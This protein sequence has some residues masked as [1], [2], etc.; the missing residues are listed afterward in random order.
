MAKATSVVDDVIGVIAAQ[1]PRVQAWYH[2][3][4]P[5]HVATLDELLQAWKSGR[6]GTHKITAS[7][8]ISRIL[9]ARGIA[10]VGPQGVLAWLRK[11][12]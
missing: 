2:R 9:A 1:P 6:L 8:A 3:V 5:K 4:L 12:Q 7:R 10:D 11:A